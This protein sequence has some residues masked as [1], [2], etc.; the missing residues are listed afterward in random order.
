MSR[1]SEKE[2]PKIIAHAPDKLRILRKCAIHIIPIFA[3]VA[4]AVLNLAK[5]FFGTEIPGL[6]N[7]KW[8][9][10]YGLGLQVASKLHEL[11]IIAS[12]S[13]VLMDVLRYELLYSSTGLPFGILTAKTRFVNVTYLISPEFVFGV[14]KLSWRKAWVTLLVVLF[15]LLAVLAGP[16]SAL[17]MIPKTRDNWVAGRA[18]FSM[19]GTNESIW[20]LKLDGSSIGGSHCLS[21]SEVHFESQ[22]MNMSSCTW[23][24]YQSILTSFLSWGWESN[25]NSVD[26]SVPIQGRLKQTITLDIHEAYVS[27]T[28]VNLP[29]CLYSKALEDTWINA[30]ANSRVRS[31]KFFTWANLRYRNKLGS[32]VYIKSQL[33]FVKVGCIVNSS[34]PFSH[35][36]NKTFP[37]TNFNDSQILSKWLEEPEKSLNISRF[38]D[39]TYSSAYLAVLI[40]LPNAT[41]NVLV[42]CAIDAN[43]MGGNILK[44]AAAQDKTNLPYI[45][46]DIADAQPVQLGMDLLSA[47]TPQQGNFTARNSLSFLLGNLGLYNSTRTVSKW[48]AVRIVIETVVSTLIVNGMSR[49]RYEENVGLLDPF[50]FIDLLSPDADTDYSSIISGSYVLPLAYN[51]AGNTSNTTKM[52]WLMTVTGMGYWAE[53]DSYYFALAL[54]FAHV[55]IAVVHIGWVIYTRETSTTWS[56][57]SDL[58][59]LTIKSTPPAVALKNTSAGIGGYKA[60]K[61][62]VR[63]RATSRVITAGVSSPE[64]AVQ[65]SGE[66][67]IVFQP[68]YSPSQHKEVMIGQLY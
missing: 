23:W 48:D 43:W 3:T 26:V 60:F 29:A 64:N 42:S 6:N 62:P 54:L 7:G 44:P 33:P 59:T 16:S 36:S 9:S 35:V 17:L 65:S 22:P 34:M 18:T 46:R 53:S 5:Y 15:T 39:F 67:E 68:D 30:V 28:G 10:F 14:L 51:V 49:V 40:P 11:F 45:A 24:G 61:E 38:A 50:N 20:P 1:L 27:A 47:L 56:S 63:I 52:K 32:N 66:V 55:I 57:L 19:V 41:V 8:Q 12:L 13:T 21:P 37:T 25:L 2:S 4:L 31:A 58:I